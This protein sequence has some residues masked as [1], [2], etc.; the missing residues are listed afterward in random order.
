MAWDDKG[1][2]PVLTLI[3]YRGKDGE[4]S[5]YGIGSEEKA[6]FPVWGS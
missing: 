3:L 4:D 5:C 6:G 1:I 2:L